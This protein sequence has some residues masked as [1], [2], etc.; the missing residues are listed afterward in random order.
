MLVELDLQSEVPLY[1]QLADQLIEGLASGALK[2]GEPLPSVRSLAADLN[3]NLHTVNK[4]YQVLKQ[5][6]FLQVH[7]KQGVVIHPDGMPQVTYAFRERLTK[8]LR[9]LA[10]E[11]IVRGMTE[12]EFL[13]QCGFV[14]R[15]RRK[16]KEEE[17]P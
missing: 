13:Q 3:I 10:A 7:R 11:A 14:F 6:G 9:P 8:Q 1:T 15:G 12:E 4:A 17:Q 16:I 2:P 5:D